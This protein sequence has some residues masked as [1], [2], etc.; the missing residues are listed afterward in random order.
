MIGVQNHEGTIIDPEGKIVFA[1][2][3]L[4]QARDIVFPHAILQGCPLQ[5]E[6]GGCPVLPPYTPPC[7]LQRLEYLVAL[8]G[9]GNHGRP[10]VQHRRA[11][12]VIELR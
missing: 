6:P 2:C 12:P 8:G 10:A 5:P 4:K 1:T 11:R 9:F 7:F 3:S